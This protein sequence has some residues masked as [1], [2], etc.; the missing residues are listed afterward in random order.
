MQVQIDLQ[1]ITSQIT[2]IYENKSIACILVLRYDDGQQRR[3]MQKS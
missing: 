1:S 2:A 3:N